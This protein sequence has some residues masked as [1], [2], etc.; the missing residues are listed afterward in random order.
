[1]VTTQLLPRTVF[2][3]A[4]DDVR[5][6]VKREGKAAG[7]SALLPP[8]R[9]PHLRQACC[10]LPAAAVRC[11]RPRSGTLQGSQSR[12]VRGPSC[13][14]GM[15]PP[16]RAAETPRGAGLSAPATSSR[17]SASPNGTC[18]PP[19]QAAEAST[20]RVSRF[21]ASIGT[22]DSDERENVPDLSR[23]RQSPASGQAGR[24]AIRTLV[25]PD[26]LAALSVSSPKGDVLRR[27]SAATP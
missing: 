4:R 10:S 5:V 27:S 7:F 22:K 6:F 12:C 8:D 18:S 1:L 26:P 11:R 13:P 17:D 15:H 25:V 20:G 14:S 23:A 21:R 19:A 9:Q 3:D 24:P 2:L 16:R